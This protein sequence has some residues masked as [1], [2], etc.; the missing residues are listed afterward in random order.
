MKVKVIKNLSPAFNQLIEN[1]ILLKLNDIEVRD[2]NHFVDISSYLKKG[3]IQLEI[4]RKGQKIMKEI[5]IL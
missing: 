1:D 2:V 5:I 4:L 3:N